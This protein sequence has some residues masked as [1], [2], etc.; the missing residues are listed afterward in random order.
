MFVV[1]SVVGFVY[2]RAHLKKERKRQQIARSHAEMV[3][4]DERQKRQ[5]E[6]AASREIAAWQGQGT[7]EA[8]APTK[9]PVVVAETAVEGVQSAS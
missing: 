9:G 1:L 7:R 5:A 4:F 8:D 6:M 3:K 2:R